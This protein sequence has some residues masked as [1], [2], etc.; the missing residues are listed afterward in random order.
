MPYRRFR[1]RGLRL[2]AL[3]AGASLVPVLV[4][5]VVLGASYRHDA[6]QG[7]LQQGLA[8]AAV[9]E[10]MSIGPALL[11]VSPGLRLTDA[12]EI[13]LYAVSNEAIF[14]GSVAQLNLVNFDGQVVFASAGDREQRRDTT[15]A[16]FRRVES[17]TP[18]AQFD[19]T[20]TR[21]VRVLEPVVSERNGLPIGILEIRFPYD[22]IAKVV[23]HNTHRGYLRLG[24]G[25]L[26]LYVML[27]LISWWTTR[28]LRRDAAGHEHRALHDPLTGLPNRAL[29]RRLAERALAESSAERKGGLVLVDLNRFKE[30]NDTLG[31]AAGDELL[32]VVARRL[33]GAFR[34]DDVVARLGG[35]EF[36]VLL[37]RV[38]DA[39]EAM[40]LME[41]A[42]HEIREDVAVDGVVIS[43]DASLGLCLFPDDA[44]DVEELLQHADTAMYEGKRGATKIVTYAP[45]IA[46]AA[47][48]PLVLQRELAEAIA[49]DQLFVEYQPKVL[50]ATGRTVGVEALVRWQH[51]Q[52]GRMSPDEFIPVAERSPLI[53]QL[54]AWVV[55]RALR[56]CAAWQQAGADWTLSV[57]VSARNLTAPDVVQRAVEATRRYGVDP[58][59]LIL[60]LTE[61]MTPFD[62]EVLRRTVVDLQQAG[63]RVSLDDFGAGV[64]NL[65][66][67][68]A[69]P[70]AEI[71]IDRQFV[72]RL[73]R[74]PA[75]EAVVASIIDLGHR[76]GCTVT[77][78]G[79]ESAEVAER[80]AAYGC[81][82][83]QGYYWQ[84]PTAWRELL[85][86]EVLTAAQP[87]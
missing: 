35:D 49:E 15:T 84:R 25:L 16:A 41:R 71:K 22:H 37:R 56:D 77:A 78:E 21:A 33:V 26:A 67:L 42:R 38:H 87:T 39:E 12:Q 64:T 65:A 24:L 7:A 72:D 69:I 81:D 18:V 79:V 29:F 57:N 60:E 76:L 34:S 36:A 51:P 28:A 54:T 47:L 30:V 23:E 4:L 66:Q 83:G 8:Q 45:A 50:L 53:D 70:V 61:T 2:F 14:K 31:H 80:L 1:A 73:D 19:M 62:D 63:I 52:R 6:E 58:E 40:V 27:A 55:D 46:P 74:E 17:G 9:I 85:A 20:G 48:S 5:G 75:S 3:Y 82:L 11:D 13:K 68:R 59:R 44:G 32:R 10:Q 43:I 86:Q